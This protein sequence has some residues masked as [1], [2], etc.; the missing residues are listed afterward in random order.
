MYRDFC[1]SEAYGLQQMVATR[2]G[3]H[4]EIL[5]F[6]RLLVKRLRKF[7]VP[8]FAAAVWRRGCAVELIHGVLG[9]KLPA[10]S[11]EIIGH[12]GKELA[13]AKGWKINWGGDFNLPDPA[14][15][16]LANWRSR[17]DVIA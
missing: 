5:D 4:E 9:R 10:R 16:Q 7:G 3:A 12:M 14:R 1:S 6:E 11:W 13:A 2:D 8:M 15:W 17:F